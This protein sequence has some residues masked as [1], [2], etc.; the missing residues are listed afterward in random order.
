MKPDPST[1]MGGG[2]GGGQMTGHF[3]NAPVSKFLI[4]SSVVV[5][6]IGVIWTTDPNVETAFSFWGKFSID[7]GILGFQ[8]WRV[9]TFQFLHADGM[10]LLS[11]MI[12]IYFF[13]PHVERWM[14]SRPFTFYY[15]F[16]GI[17]GALFYA[18]L[19]FLPGFFSGQDVSIGMVGASAGIFGILAAFYKIAPNARILLF[20]FIPLKV[21]TAA[22][23]YFV[24]EVSHVV[25][26]LNNA[27]GS[28]GHLGGA[29]LGLSFI[30]YKPLRTWLIKISQ[31]G[32]GEKPSPKVRTATVVR[33]T[34]SP[35]EVSK[36]VDRIL[37]KISSEG[38]QSLTP[39]E[40]KILEKARRN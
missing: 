40:R 20:F 28:A 36:E 26:G 19:Y 37:E 12:G 39:K 6:L 9:L 27:G 8:I 32:T 13:G 24:W 33:E 7:K 29:F 18:L 23:L 10:H 4:V 1:P 2:G 22:I 38:M 3:A 15:F 14:G 11:N 30:N 34:R 31:I 35:I 16:C 17:A 5:F 25:F 21:R